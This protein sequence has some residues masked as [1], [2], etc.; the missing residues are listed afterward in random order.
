[1]KKVKIRP[2][3]FTELL[4]S[5]AVARGRSRTCA[6]P[7]SREADDAS[8]DWFKTYADIKNLINRFV[9]NK[10]A[11][12]VMLGCGNSSAFPFP[13]FPRFELRLMIRIF[14]ALS[15]DLYDDGYKRVEN[16]DYSEVVIEKMARVNAERSEM[17]W[18]VGDVRNL[19]FEDGSIDVCIDKGTMDAMM[20]SKGDVWNPAPEVV[21]NVKGEVDEVVRVLKPDG[22]FLYLTF[23][24]P[25]FRR[26]HLQRPGWKLE[27]LEVGVDVG[28]GYF[29]YVLR[30]EGVAAL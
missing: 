24:Q 16:I 2:G 5:C 11:R 7:S 1:M 20:T 3:R 8:F 6:P 27:V 4:Y 28:F 17:T 21:A 13:S 14:T 18:I 9:P 26:Q 30:R 19:P 23:G 12:I 29:F 25:H 10:D 15:R 22:V